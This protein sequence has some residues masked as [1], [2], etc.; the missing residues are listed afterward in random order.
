MCVWAGL[1]T[2]FHFQND[3]VCLPL[4][5]SRS[6]GNIGQIVICNR[7]TTAVQL[8]NP[9][10]LQ[11]KIITVYSILS[12]F[13]SPGADVSSTVYWRT[14][15]LPLCHYR[16]LQEFYVLHMEELPVSSGA[17]RKDKVSCYNKKK[18]SYIVSRF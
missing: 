12:I 15:F 16:Q 4:K 6:L 5:L 11:S 18:K 8:I 7:V 17:A 3:V 14:P 1:V 9:Q 13:V 10:T 2:D